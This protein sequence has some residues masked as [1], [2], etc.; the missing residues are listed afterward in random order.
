MLP[1]C[2]NSNSEE[3]VFM[4]HQSLLIKFKSES[5]ILLGAVATSVEL[6]YCLQIVEAKVHQLDFA[7]ERIFLSLKEITVSMLSYCNSVSG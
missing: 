3:I 6:F 4:Y 2:P 1:A 5:N 7:L